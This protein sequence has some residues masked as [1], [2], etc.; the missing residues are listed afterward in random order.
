MENIEESDKTIF[1]YLREMLDNK[2]IMYGEYYLLVQSA[3]KSI[4]NAVCMYRD[5]V[6]SG[7]VYGN[8]C[9]PIQKQGVN[10]LNNVV[11]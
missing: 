6:G 10:W 3:K 2:R 7:S 4:N 11:K 5:G 1:H 8:T 9:E